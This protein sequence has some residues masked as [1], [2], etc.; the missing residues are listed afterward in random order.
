MAAPQMVSAAIE[1]GVNKALKWSSN[2]EGLL[3]PLADKT[4]IIYIQELESAL[5]FSFNERYI[6]VSSDTDSLYTSI[7]DDNGPSALYDNECW[8]SISFF[9]LDKL[10]QN[11]QMTKLIKSGKLDF[12]GDLGILQGVSRLFDKLDIDVEEVMSTYVGDAAAYQINSSGKKLVASIG[13]QLSILAVTLA[14]TAL[15]EKPIGV[16]PIIVMNFNDEVNALR[17]DFD[18]FEARLALMEM[19]L[20][21]AMNVKQGKST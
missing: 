7:P 13:Q 21:I 20:K 11:N 1:A 19:K 3:K 18:R 2:S 6:S 17:A 14:D 16:R 8:V 12:S 5:I 4:C 10:K 9:A 15:D